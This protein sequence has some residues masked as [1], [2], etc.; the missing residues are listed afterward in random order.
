MNYIKMRGSALGLT[1]LLALSLLISACSES[2][3]EASLTLATTAVPASVSISVAPASPAV[4]LTPAA[5]QPSAA[6]LNAA[7]TATPAVFITRSSVA[8][9]TASGSATR[10]ASTTTPGPTA[11]PKSTA[12]PRPNIAG[13]NGFQGKLSILGP[14]KA[15][16]LLRF[17]GKGPQ[18]ALG[19]AG[20]RA[21]QN[22]DGA[23]YEWPTWTNDG[24]RLAVMS[25]NVKAGNIASSD[26]IVVDA[27]GKNPVKV[28]DGSSSSPIFMTWSPD[29]RLLALLVNGGSNQLEL[30]LLDTEPGLSA[31]AA[32]LRKVA[33]GNAVYTGWSPDGQHLLIHASSP[34]SN[35][36]SLLAARDNKAVPS[37]LK[38]SPSNFRS[39]AFSSDGALYAFAVEN[40]LSGKEEIAVS[41][42][43][44]KSLGNIDAG[45]TGVAFNW[46]PGANRLAFTTMLQDGQGFYKG[47][48]LYEPSTGASLP[49]SQIANEPV[50]SFFWSPDGKKLAYS[51]FNDAG[52]LLQWKIY[53]LNSKQSTTMVEWYPSESWIQM[54]QYFDQY[55]QTNSI[56]SPDSKALVF[57]GFTKEDVAAVKAQNISDEDVVPT[58]YIL[59][60]EGPNAGK[61][62][63]VAPGSLA[64]WSR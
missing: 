30:R 16:Y 34:Q 25:F 14:E 64:F 44:G 15:L 4:L 53:D 33:A 31:T 61:P 10:I 29:G 11:A 21:G 41:D 46:S 42:K 39:P 36:L 55:A 52:D 58:V 5:P 54:M 1:S 23:I 20:V 2:A 19:T 18:L 32:T 17:D 13:A 24:T 40:T 7:V 26:I 22:Q 49:A 50:A 43:A 51:G 28:Q 62:V 38:G 63:A 48:A 45:G 6:A 12:T 47:I 8:V 35:A 37:A 27:D 3:P 60:V 57:A 59:P 9:N 56:W